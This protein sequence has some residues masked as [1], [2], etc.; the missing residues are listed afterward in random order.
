MILDNI[1]DLVIMIGVK[2]NGSFPILYVNRPLS[3][4]LGYVESDII[5]REIAEVVGEDYFVTLHKRYM[6]VIN[7][8]KEIHYKT[9]LEGPAGAKYL[10][11][12][13]LPVLNSVGEC[14]Q[15]IGITREVGTEGV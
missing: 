3:R 1:N 5:G 6:K 15:L 7:T 2:P 4:C 8:K 12:K 9:L 10:E 14:I 13:L 11:V